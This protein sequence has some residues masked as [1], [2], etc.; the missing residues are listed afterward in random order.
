[1]VIVNSRA[2]Y[3]LEQLRLGSMLSMCQAAYMQSCL[4]CCHKPAEAIWIVGL[5]FR[6]R[7][8]L[9]CFWFSPSRPSCVHREVQ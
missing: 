8:G 2:C 7:E 5:C 3:H 9:G 6:E 4:A 1:M